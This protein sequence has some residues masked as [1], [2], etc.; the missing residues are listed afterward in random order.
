MLL[1]KHEVTPV[2][3]LVYIQIWVLSEVS[4]IKTNYNEVVTI[5][6]ELIW[7]INTSIIQICIIYLF[8][9]PELFIAGAISIIIFSNH[10]DFPP[11]AITVD[12]DTDIGTFDIYL[13]STCMP[14]GVTVF[15]RTNAD[16]SRPHI[17][18]KTSLILILKQQKSLSPK[19]VFAKKWC[20]IGRTK[21][22]LKYVGV[23]TFHES[24]G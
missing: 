12:P 6:H 19:F 9:T 20:N 4:T 11:I 17:V 10:T 1:E 13:T 18:V 24:C 7:G 21:E 8:W 23:I 5:T 14:G 15:P 3:E 16:T 22:A 2:E